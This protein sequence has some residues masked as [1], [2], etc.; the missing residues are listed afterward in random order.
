[1]E[2]SSARAADV[3]ARLGGAQLSFCRPHGPWQKG[4]VEN[5]NGLI[6]G[7]FPKGTDFS[8]VTGEVVERAFASINGRPRRVL[9]NRTA[10]GAYREE[11]LHSA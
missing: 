1:M 10:S 7:F 5:T 8:R 2:Q 11:L 4:T 3:T 9:A 6:R